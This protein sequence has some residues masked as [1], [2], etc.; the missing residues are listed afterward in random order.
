M[1]KKIPHTGDTRPSRTCV[2]FD[3]ECQKMLKT[4]LK[5]S[6]WSKMVQNGQQ[7]SLRSKTLKNGQKRSKKQSKMVQNGPNWLTTVNNSQQR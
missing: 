3:Q 2:I 4:E 6:K 7:R 1:E 5:W